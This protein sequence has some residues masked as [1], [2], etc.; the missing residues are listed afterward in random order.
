MDILSKYNRIYLESI[1]MFPEVIEVGAKEIQSALDP[2]KTKHE[3]RQVLKYVPC[4]DAVIFYAVYD[5]KDEK[6][7]KMKRS[8]GDRQKAV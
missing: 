7:R 4:K 2:I 3:A 6:T 8:N 5:S 1:S